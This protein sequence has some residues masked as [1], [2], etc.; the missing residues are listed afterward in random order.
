[1]CPESWHILT[2]GI[3]CLMQIYF[4]SYENHVTNMCVLHRHAPLSLKGVILPMPIVSNIESYP[5]IPREECP[6]V[7]EIFWS[8]FKPFW[9]VGNVACTTNYRCVTNLNVFFQIEIPRRNLA[10]NLNFHKYPVWNLRRPSCSPGDRSD[11]RADRQGQHPRHQRLLRPG[12]SLSKASRPQGSLCWAAATDW[13]GHPWPRNH[14]EYCSSWI[15]I[16]KKARTHHR[17]IA[18]GGQ[19]NVLTVSM[20]G[21]VVGPF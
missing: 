2:T 21:L 19:D 16:V 8:S 18:C 12:E 14:C 6:S 9:Y 5:K 3:C 4:C 1:M 20:R 17:S 10:W 15:Q 7:P 13:N 11:R